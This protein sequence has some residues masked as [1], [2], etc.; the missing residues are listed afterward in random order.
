M[1]HA[2][3]QCKKDYSVQS[4]LLSLDEAGRK[5]DMDYDVYGDSIAASPLVVN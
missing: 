3:L 1:R 4:G 5:G 2:R